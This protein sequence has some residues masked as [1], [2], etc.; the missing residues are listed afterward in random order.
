MGDPGSLFPG[1]RRLGGLAGLAGPLESDMESDDSNDVLETE[2]ED[3]GDIGSFASSSCSCSV[4][5]RRP[6]KLLNNEMD[7]DRPLMARLI[8]EIP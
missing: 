3:E 4:D 8:E 2:M 6:I 1:V 7:K 5:F